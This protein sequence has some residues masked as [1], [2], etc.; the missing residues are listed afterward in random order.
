[1]ADKDYQIAEEAYGG[2]KYHI[3][4]LNELKAKHNSGTDILGIWDSFLPI[5]KLPQ[6]NVFP[7]LIH[8][9]VAC[10]DPTQRA[11]LNPSGSVVFHITPEAIREM[12]NFQI[13]KKLVPLSMTELIQQGSKL[14]DA[15][16]TK[17]NQLYIDSPNQTIRT[18]PISHV[19]LNELG[20]DLADMISPI[21]GYNSIEFIDETV[22]VIMAMFSPGKP[23]IC[24]DYATYIS[25]K[26]Q[27]QL[28]DLERERVFRY[29]SY[30]YHL[31]LY[32]QH[33]RFPFP[34]QR[35]DAQGKPRSVVY[36]SSI[37]HYRSGVPYTYNEF[38]DLF[39]H[40]AVSLLLS[41]PPPRLTDEM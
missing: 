9:C 11:M 23:P 41:S 2:S 31:I 24:Y 15:Q 36:W 33:E 12:L 8:Q 17:I 29:T 21:L 7:D 3:H 4:L 16:I 35:I 10:Y 26:I 28:M 37:F 22:L 5:F 18:P 13:A 1:L 20:R 40:P 30:I 38:I 27:E 14:T 34:I 19:Y 32:Y 6:V 25:N 39:I